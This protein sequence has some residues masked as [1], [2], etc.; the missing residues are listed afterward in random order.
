MRSLLWGDVP[1][2]CKNS[3]STDGRMTAPNQGFEQ[4]FSFRN[5]NSLVPSVQSVSLKAFSPNP[6]SHTNISTMTNHKTVYR[7]VLV[8]LCT[9]L[10][11]N[12]FRPSAL[13]TSSPTSSRFDMTRLQ[14]WSIPTPDIDMSQFKMKNSWYQECNP[15]A[16]KTVY[17]E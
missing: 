15:T 2:K 14:A 3:P 4:L 7:F 5:I 6:S 12:A 13:Q 11:A 9:S 8:I 1:L 10:V 16:R 17:N